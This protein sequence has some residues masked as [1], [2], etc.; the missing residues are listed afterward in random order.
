MKAGEARKINSKSQYL[1]QG[2]RMTNPKF[3]KAYAHLMEAGRLIGWKD[4][5]FTIKRYQEFEHPDTGYKLK[6]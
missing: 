1:K 5:S 4:L 2:N 3:I 6:H